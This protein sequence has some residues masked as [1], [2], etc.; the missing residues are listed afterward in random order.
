[1]REIPDEDVIAFVDGRLEEPTRAAFE[2]RLKDDP[3]LAKEVAAH[4]WMARQIV[5]AFGEPPRYEVD[6]ADLARLGLSATDV[7]EFP[8]RHR[9]ATRG[10]VF[11]AILSGAI[12]ASLVAGVFLGR[13]VGGSSAGILQADD[14]GR[15]VARG[16]LAESLSDQL[17]GLPGTTRIGLTFR[18]AQTVCRTF[19]TPQGL[20]GLGCR[21]AGQWI[22]PIL[23]TGRS[24]MQGETEYRL[25]GGDVAPSVMAEVDRR[26][27][28]E[29]LSPAQERALIAKDWQSDR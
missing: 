3:E 14:S 15:V 20:S 22:V 27:V 25:A 13:I 2:A 19:S 18:T 9:R 26:M 10:S 6:E 24:D 17:S 5:A 11:A 7:V 21:E 23:T 28:G 29:P 12:A 1:L 4:R 8:R 16:E